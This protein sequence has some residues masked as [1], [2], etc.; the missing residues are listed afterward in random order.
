MLTPNQLTEYMLLRDLVNG[1]AEQR[2]RNSLGGAWVV[3]LVIVED[4]EGSTK[5]A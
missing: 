3:Y 4:A 1:H 2:R 5:A